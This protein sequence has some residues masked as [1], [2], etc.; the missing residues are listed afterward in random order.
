LAW[1]SVPA[2]VASVTRV[3]LTVSHEPLVRLMLL[4]KGALQ[5]SN[6]AGVVVTAV[7]APDATQ[8]AAV[9]VVVPL[10]SVADSVNVVAAVTSA[11]VLPIV[12]GDTFDPG[13]LRRSARVALLGHTIAADLYGADSPVGQRL[14]INRIPFEVVGVLAPEPSATAAVQGVSVASTEH[15]IYLPFTT[16]L[17]K[18]DRDPMKSPLNEIVVHLEPKAPAGETGAAANQVLVA[19][20][21]LGKQAA[22]LR[23]DVD[24]FLANIRAA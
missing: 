18:L 1:H 17:R 23:A 12:A 20:E 24:T 14:F 21:E 4:V 9:S 10:E 11:V 16:A 3:T 15:E 19:A 7:T 8:T 22:T 6:V 2:G 13:D 5:T